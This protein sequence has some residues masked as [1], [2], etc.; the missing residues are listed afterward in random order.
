M[1]NEGQLRNG[2]HLMHQQGAAGSVP[3]LLTGVGLGWICL[4]LFLVADDAARGGTIAIEP[5]VVDAIF[6]AA[7]GLVIGAGR[8]GWPAL[9]G[10]FGGAIAGAAL[11]YLATKPVLGV[12]PPNLEGYGMY[13]PVTVAAAVAASVGMVIGARS[14]LRFVI[15][16]IAIIV[17]GLVVL[18]LWFGFWLVW[19]QAVRQV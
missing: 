11:P 4:P 13:P 3:R 14:R 6:G 10:V 8:L 9:L 1:S 19:A 15:R 18:A 17:T 7:V 12:T 5:V 16:P 2:P